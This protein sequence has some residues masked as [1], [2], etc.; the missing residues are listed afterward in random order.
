M[1]GISI[2]WLKCTETHKRTHTYKLRYIKIVY[3]FNHIGYGVS[4]MSCQDS[5]PIEY[6]GEIP[7]SVEGGREG[8]NED[9][10]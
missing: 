3:T 2:K 7:V 5:V 8:R 1:T 9:R 10:W 6:D 4:S